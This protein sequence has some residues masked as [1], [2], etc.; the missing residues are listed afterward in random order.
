M[1]F[2]FIERLKLAV[3]QKQVHLVEFSHMV[4]L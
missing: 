3:V 2:I 4:Y 1:V